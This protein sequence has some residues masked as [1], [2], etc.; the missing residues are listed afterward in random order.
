[1]W[2]LEMAGFSSVALSTSLDAYFV[3]SNSFS[4]F[5]SIIACDL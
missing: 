2:H 4:G 5:T 1:M 3:G